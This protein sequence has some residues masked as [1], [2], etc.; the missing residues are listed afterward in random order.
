MAI[1]SLS[2]KT[3]LYGLDE[4]AAAAAAAA[5][6][7]CFLERAGREGLDLEFEGGGVGC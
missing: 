3:L 2:L 5:V 4:S 7:V 1:S 6:G